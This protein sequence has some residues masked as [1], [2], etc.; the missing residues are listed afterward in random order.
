MKHRVQKFGK[1]LSSIIMPNI[2]A[3][4]EYIEC[5]K[6]NASD[7]QQQMQKMRAETKDRV[8]EKGQISAS[9]IRLKQPSVSKEEAICAA[10]ELLMQ[11][12]CVDEAY[13]D[14][15]IERERLLSTYMGMG[16]AIPHGTSE[17]KAF[18]KKKGIV[19][20]QY[21][22]GV[23]FGDE[24]AQLVFGIAGVGDEHIALLEKI[25]DA[26]DDEEILEEMKTTDRVE[27]ILQV[28]E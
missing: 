1:F 16:I 13:V 11:Q 22:E 23:K 5:E 18:V 3:Y 21:P 15:M 19:L 12:G 6:E 24:K 4:N 27:W 9:G 26:L 10:G 14:A 17:A 2:G 8:R 20:L 28:L 25:C 7:A